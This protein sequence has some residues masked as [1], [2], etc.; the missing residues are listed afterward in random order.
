MEVING[1]SDSTCYN[2]IQTVRNIVNHMSCTKTSPWTRNHTDTANNFNVIAVL[3]RLAERHSTIAFLTVCISFFSNT[4]FSQGFS[5]TIRAQRN[6]LKESHS[7][8][9]HPKWEEDEEVL[10][11]EALW[12]RGLRDLISA[13]LLYAG[14]SSGKAR[15][16]SM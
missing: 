14:E 12:P 5:N 7:K 9:L 8:G 16:Q 3:R 6:S 10:W 15:I 2:S 4:V 1:P 13:C 11:L